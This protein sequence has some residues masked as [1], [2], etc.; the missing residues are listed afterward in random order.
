MKYDLI[1]TE[2]KTDII[3]GRYE[4]LSRLPTRNEL[5]RR[6]ST[7]LATMQNAMDIL[8]KEGFIDSR[9][10]DGTFVVEPP[11]FQYRVWLAPLAAI[12]F[13]ETQSTCPS[14]YPISAP[15]LWRILYK[16]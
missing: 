4:P 3:R 7:T 2:L 11:T 8:T 12:S 5:A 15:L 9:G 14:Q 6:F 1:I 10:R 16:A 13:F